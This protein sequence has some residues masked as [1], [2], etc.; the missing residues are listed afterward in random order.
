MFS[1]ENNPEI[2][3]HKNC[4]YITSI[5]SDCQTRPD[6]RKKEKLNYELYK[7][8]LQT[9]QKWGNIWRIIHISVLDWIKRETEKKYKSIDDKID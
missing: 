7:I 9:A 2:R 1:Q 5:T 4:Q 6:N 8:H 3:Q